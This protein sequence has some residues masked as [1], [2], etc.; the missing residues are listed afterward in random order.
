[1][2]KAL[3]VKELR[4][5]AWIAALAL[6][7]SLLMLVTMQGVDLSSLLSYRSYGWYGFAVQRTPI[8]F[9]NDDFQSK[10][11]LVGLV[12]ATVLGFRQSIAEFTRGTYLLLLHR[13][14]RRDMIFATKLAVGAMLV[15]VVSTLTVAL[16]AW[17]AATPGTHPSPFFWSM[18]V[19]AWW[20]AVCL[21]VVYLGAFLSGVR[22]GRWLG[23]RLMP[24]V[25]SLVAYIILLALV[26]ELRWF[27]VAIAMLPV[28][29]AVFVFTI[30]YV[31]RTRDFS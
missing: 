19:P 16:Y 1:M 6:A 27:V 31:A 30:Q 23:T 9:V 20:A 15:V 26:Q 25:T 4:E 21:P 14:L 13:P 3:A 29:I 5:T 10:L 22:P 8:P 17:W 12:L 18:T 2:K 7:A 28:A 24:L 11:I